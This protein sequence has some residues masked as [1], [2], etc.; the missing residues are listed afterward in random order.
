M[1]DLY[2]QLK[3]NDKNEIAKVYEIFNWD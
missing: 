1:G 2:K 3:I